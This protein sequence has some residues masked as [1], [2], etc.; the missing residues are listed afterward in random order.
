VT[1]LAFG[2]VLAS[3]LAHATWNYLAKRSEDTWAFTWAFNA[4][5]AIVYLPFAVATSWA[6]P[7]SVAAL[8]LIL[9]TLALHI[10]YFNLL[11]AGYARADLSIVYPVARGTGLLLI[12]IGAALFL[13]E[14][15]PPVGAGCIALIFLGVLVVH[16]RGGGRAAIAT[17]ARP[18]RSS[19][20]VL[21]VLTGFAIAGYSLWD[22]H[23]L[24][25]LSPIVLDTGIFVGLTLANAPYAFAAKRRAILREVRVNRRAVIAAGI[26][27]PLA[28]LL[29]LTALTFSQI[30]YVAPTREIGIVVGALLGARR[31]KEPD[32]A[33]RILGSLL[34]V[35][36]VFG[37]AILP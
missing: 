10:A 21:A 11:A 6:R 27:S 1:A 5:S 19:G 29:V 18:L 12:P 13:G 22:K 26:L 14:R 34:I 17:L 4:V 16:S 35:A 25:Q 2:L 3:A 9:V 15:I 36:G 37:L 28:Y 7:P 32:P 31:L 8:S 30:S 33:N 23:A 24:G 20:S